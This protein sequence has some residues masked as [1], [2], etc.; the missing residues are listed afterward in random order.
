MKKIKLYLMIGM[1]A[2][3]LAGCGQTGSQPEGQSGGQAEEQTGSRTEGQTGSQ[4][5]DQSGDGTEGQSGGRAEGQT[6]SRTEGQTGGQADSQPEGQGESQAGQPDAGA[7]AAYTFTDDLGREVTVES[8]ERVATLLGSY[9]DMWILAGGDVCAAPDDAFVDLDLPLGE[10]TV[11]LG[12]TKRLSLEL[13]LSADPDFVLASTNTSQHLEWQSSLEGAGI[14]VAYFDVSCFDDYL[15][16]LK[17]CTDITGQPERY[18]QYGTDIQKEINEILSRNAGK[19]A[20]T[21]L[22]MRASAT[23]IRAKGNGGNVLGEML[24]SF[25]CVNIADTDDSLLESLSLESIMLMDPDLIL[26][27][28]SGDD[29]EG[30][31]ENI[32]NMFRENPL[33]NELGAVKNG[34]VHVLDKHLYNLKPNARWAEAYE[35]LE[36]LLYPGSDD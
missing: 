10:D 14:T 8:Y 35:E 21:V 19:S 26:I 32:E 33:W 12:E 31:Q 25:G 15:R 16:V 2:V 23:S 24:E 1:M 6:G 4:S 7:D 36:R 20:P 27:V 18:T 3:G 28:Q 13:L 29:I 34:Q 17:T 30:T 9:A 22:S 5:E 11:N